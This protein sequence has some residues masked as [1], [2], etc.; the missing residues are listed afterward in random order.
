MVLDIRR[1][2]QL[3]DCICIMVLVRGL[4]SHMSAIFDAADR[5]K[6]ETDAE[7]NVTSYQYDPSGNLIA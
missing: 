3:L 1:H 4:P 7:G 2:D 5:S 6:T